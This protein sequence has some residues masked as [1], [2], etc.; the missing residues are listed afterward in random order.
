MNGIKKA[1]VLLLLASSGKVMAVAPE[2]VG[3]RSFIY[4]GT[5]CPLQ[6]AE[7]HLAQDDRG[8]LVLS[9]PNMLA[10]W[11]PNHPKVYSRQNCVM[12]VDLVVPEGW[13]YSLNAWEAIGTV[14]LDSG[15]RAEVSFQYFFEGSSGQK[16][17]H[18]WD[19]PENLDFTI[20]DYVPMESRQWSSCGAPR[21]FNMNT[22]VRVMPV[23]A[24][25]VPEGR[26]LL[27]LGRHWETNQFALKL[28]WRRCSP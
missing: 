15:L 16:L 11:G 8:S 24:E 21:K 5:G 22:K 12:T 4:N 9:L 13:Q 14:Y 6:S 7:I 17:V 26:G 2:G 3:I 20:R 28:D 19:G 23:N 10:E 1:S 18:N 25:P 27:E